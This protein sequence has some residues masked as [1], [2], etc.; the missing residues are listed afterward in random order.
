MTNNDNNT[1]D[2]KARKVWDV[3]TDV[4]GFLGQAFLGLFGL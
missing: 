3:V 4:L 1:N 2:S